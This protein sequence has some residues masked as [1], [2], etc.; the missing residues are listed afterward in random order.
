MPVPI[1]TVRSRRDFETIVAKRSKHVP[2]AAGVMGP[3]GVKGDIRNFYDG[4][5]DILI[6]EVV[7]LPS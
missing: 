6:G 5:P 4:M 2:L 7:A 1:C 3:Y